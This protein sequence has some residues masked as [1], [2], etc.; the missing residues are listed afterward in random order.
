M[1]C[2]ILLVED[3]AR[4]RRNIALFLE[5]QNHKVSQAETG[6]AA[7]DLL[8]SR[9]FDTVISDFRLPGAINGLDVLR[10]QSDKFPGKRLV[11]ITAFG[12]E[13]V[14]SAAKALDALYFEKPI[15]LDELLS[16]LHSPS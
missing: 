14:Q 6:E 13:D 7:L 2:S 11:L 8:A 5:Q 9:N 16:S 4:S 12:S 3:E 1:A 15:S 10:S